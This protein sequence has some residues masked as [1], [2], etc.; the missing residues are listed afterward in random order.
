M[1]FVSV[2]REVLHYRELESRT[3]LQLYSR[4]YHAFA[5]S[6]LSYCLKAV[7]L[8]RRCQYL[9]CACAVLVHQHHSFEICF[10]VLRF[11]FCLFTVLVLGVGHDAFIQEFIRDI[12]T[13]IHQTSTVVS[14][15]EN[16]IFRTFVLDILQRLV[17]ILCSVF[18]EARYP[19]VPCIIVDHPA[20]HAFLHY[21]CS[22]KGHVL[23]VSVAIVG[24]F[25]FRSLFPSYG[26]RHDVHVVIFF[27]VYLQDIIAC[28]ESGVM[29]R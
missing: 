19:D 14:Q 23:L 7:V 18:Q 9:R 21:I 17:E 29:R 2:R 1:Y 24:N 6:V 3:I 5:E 25:D 12:H 11:I 22:H 8:Q 20:G 4:L 15:V 27:P 16:E 26:C 13:G 28:L 10:A